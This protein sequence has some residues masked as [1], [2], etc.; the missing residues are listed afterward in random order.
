MK[1]LIFTLTILL[2]AVAVSKGQNLIARQ[3][4]GAPTFYTK[5]PD[6]VAAAAAGD[7]LYIPGGGWDAV[8]INKKLYLIGVG[9]NPDSTGV[10]GRTMINNNIT[11]AIGSDNGS[12]TGIYVTGVTTSGAL[13][14]Y[15]FSRCYIAQVYLNTSPNISNITFTENMIG[16]V[17]VTGSHYYMSNN[18]FFSGTLGSSGAYLDGSVVRNNVFLKYLF[19][20]GGGIN[21][22]LFASNCII[23]NNIF[24]VSGTGSSNTYRNNVNAGI[25]GTDGSNQ[26]SGNFSPSLNPNSGAPTTSLQSIFVNFDPS[27]INGDD[28]Y[29][30]D[31][32]VLNG[33]LY[34]N[35]GTDGTDIGIY[36]GAF[37]WKAGS[38]PFNPHFQTLKIAPQ[39]DSS[40]NLKVQIT[41]AAQNN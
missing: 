5:L 4:G 38:I 15:T 32:H 24:I 16:S 36:G 17:D 26:G 27:N 25:N 3:H 31:L 19:T 14:N 29:K 12:M 11:L 28:I 1:R 23:E 34:K 39:T 2:A 10:T 33:S 37:P 22:P 18:I 13:T 6:A 20:S 30:A 21:P 7:T 8:T 40:G 41:V 9:H 35:A